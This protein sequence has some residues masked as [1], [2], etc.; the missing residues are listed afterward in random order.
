MDK[1]VAVVLLT[2][3]SSTERTEYALE[4]LRSVTENLRFSGNL[5]LH[6]ADDG[7]PPEHVAFLMDW[8]HVHWREE[9]SAT[10]SDRGGYGA[11]YNLATQVVHSYADYVLPLEDD[12]RLE[13]PLDLDPLVAALD[14]GPMGCIRL[15]YLGYTRDGGLRGKI[16]SR[17]E[18]S[19]LLFDEDSEEP[20][21]WAGHPR[22][23]TVAW[24]REVGEW[25]EHREEGGEHGTMD[26]GSVE[27]LVCHYK[28]AR[29]GVAWP[30]DLIPPELFA[31]IGSR[32]STE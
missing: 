5:R 12:W 18:R 16:I 2:Y 11:N 19:Y 31:H 23:E 13:R 30:L 21:V 20:H 27:F 24:Q 6:I 29:R 3:G 7:S 4:T 9:V 8:A 1:T 15:G 14:E 17:A 22:L 25:P 10:D 28:A 26:P 32:R